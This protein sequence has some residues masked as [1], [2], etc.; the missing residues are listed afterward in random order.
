[1]VRYVISSW[2]GKGSRKGATANG[3]ELHS[4]G[5]TTQGNSQ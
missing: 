2:P 4:T 1:M 3:D 5:T